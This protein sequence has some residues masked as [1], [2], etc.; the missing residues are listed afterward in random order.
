MRSLLLLIALLSLAAC[1]SASIGDFY[2]PPGDFPQ[3]SVSEAATAEAGAY[4]VDG[5]LERIICEDDTP[6]DCI[7]G[8][9]WLYESL[10]EDPVQ[11][12]LLLHADEPD[13]FRERVRYRLSVETEMEI[14]SPLRTFRVIGATRV[15]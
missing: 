4:N 14:G 3:L 6:N 7:P 5:Y 12:A 11:L 9:N 2:P 15:N 1:D 13:V 8:T 10:A